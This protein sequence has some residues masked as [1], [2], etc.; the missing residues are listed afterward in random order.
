MFLRSIPR[1]ETQKRKLL[2]VQYYVLLLHDTPRILLIVHI[3]LS[4]SPICRYWSVLLLF[5]SQLY[6]VFLLL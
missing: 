4:E 3:G 2:G 1:P 5:L 6:I